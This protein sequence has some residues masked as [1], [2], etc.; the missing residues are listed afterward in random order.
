M[1]YS[2]DDGGDD[3]DDKE[4]ADEVEEEENN[5]NGGSDDGEGD[6]SAKLYFDLWPTTP[7][8]KCKRRKGKEARDNSI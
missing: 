3:D 6:P 8:S 7:H 5:E 4:E 2:N 1:S